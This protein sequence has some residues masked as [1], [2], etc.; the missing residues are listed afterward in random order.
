[1][2]PNST[3]KVVRQ[4]LKTLSEDGVEAVIQKYKAGSST[5]VLAD[6]FE[7]HRSTISAVLKRNG[8]TVTKRK[9]DIAV[10]TQMYE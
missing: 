7:Y 8:V 4:Q 1:M 5:Y 9:L 2:I 10:A 6:E 3:V